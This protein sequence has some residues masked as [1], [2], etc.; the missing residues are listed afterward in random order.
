MDRP[1]LIKEFQ[2]PG[3][4]H[5]SDP[6]D[7]PKFC[8]RV[9]G[10]FCCEEHHPATFQGGVG[11]ICL[12]LPRGFCR[13]GPG[14]FVN[15]FIRIWEEY[16]KWNKFNVPV[17]AMVKDGFLFV[18]TYMPR[19]NIAFVD[20]IPKGELSFVPKEAIDVSHFIDEID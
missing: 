16:P 17:W 7:C 20:V 18:R 1:G 19:L 14:K 12:G 3:C 4:I 9:D 15:P 2:C 5:G 6:N 8:L 10:F 11:R 13:F